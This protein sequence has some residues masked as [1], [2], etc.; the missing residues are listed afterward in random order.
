MA[1]ASEAPEFNR[2]LEADIRSHPTLIWQPPDKVTRG[3]SVARDLLSAMTP[4]LR[5]FE[6]RLHE[7]IAEVR[8]S[9]A[10]AEHHPFKGRCPERY[11]LTIIASVLPAGGYHPPHIH[12]GAWLSGTY[13]VRMPEAVSSD[14]PEGW[15]EF[16]SPDFPLP[17]FDPEVR[18]IQPQAGLALFFPSY[19]YHGTVPFAGDGERISIAF[20]V[21]AA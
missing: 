16:G 21:Y 10:A 11:R 15:I 19:F 12:E 8:R 17:G 4:A 3:G 18:R 13:Y 2:A 20:D 9:V 7:A 1:D 6:E 5:A 14:R